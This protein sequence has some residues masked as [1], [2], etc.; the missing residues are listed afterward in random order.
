M[1]NTPP[2]SIIFE[3]DILYVCLANHSI[4]KGH[5]IVFWKDSVQ[6]LHLL[7]RQEYEYLMDTVDAARNA[8]LRVF[9]LDK[10]YLLYMDELKQVHWHL[11]PRYNEKGFD[12]FSHLPVKIAEF[13]LVDKLRVELKDHHSI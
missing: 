11:V 7:N 6:D 8:L 13:P 1:I 9:G 4:T 12:V 2:E 10:V 3:N 5:T